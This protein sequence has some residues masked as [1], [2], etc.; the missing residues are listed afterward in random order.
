MLCYSEMPLN[1][2]SF[3]KGELIPSLWHDLHKGVNN[4]IF[5]DFQKHQVL[6]LHFHSA[7]T[8]TLKELWCILSMIVYG[9]SG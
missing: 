1:Y 9:K 8:T 6:S 5:C 7:H 4:V 3:Q 2:L